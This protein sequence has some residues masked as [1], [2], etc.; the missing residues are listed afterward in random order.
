MT[1]TAYVVAGFVVTVGTVA[2]YTAAVRARIR[3]AERAV[4]EL[5]R[6]RDGR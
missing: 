1:S 5:R 3:T 6:S 4:F 2:G